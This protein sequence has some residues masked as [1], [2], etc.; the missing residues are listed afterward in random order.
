MELREVRIKIYERMN[1]QISTD[2]II[3]T[4]LVAISEF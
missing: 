4:R 2:L 1:Q 3:F